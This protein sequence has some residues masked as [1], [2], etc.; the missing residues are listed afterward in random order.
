MSCADL[1]H[2]VL[3]VHTATPPVEGCS[4]HLHFLCLAAPYAGSGESDGCAVVE[5][6]EDTRSECFRHDGLLVFVL[7]LSC[8]VANTLEGGRFELLAD[9]V[10]GGLDDRVL[11]LCAGVN[12]SAKL[13][14]H[15]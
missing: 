3:Y 14:D 9:G 5:G 10:T 12:D 11:D 7:T 4:S 2:G 8:N 15:I 6:V 13:L 1:G